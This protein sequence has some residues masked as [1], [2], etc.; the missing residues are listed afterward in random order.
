VKVL[1]CIAW[2]ACFLPASAADWRD[3]LTPPQPGAI[4]ALRPLKAT[5]EFGWSGLT[6]A[7]ANFD[8]AK[9]KGGQM[10]LL[11]KART[12]GAARG[13]WRM[14]TDHVAYCDAVT[15]QPI[16]LEQKEVYK[17][18]S[19]IAKVRFFPDYLERWNESQ[20]PGDTPPKWRK[21]KL[22]AFDLQTALFFIRS[23][24]LETGDVYRIVVYPGKG[25]YLAEVEVIGKEMVKAGG[26]K[27]PAIKCQLRLQGIN[28]ELELEPHAKFKQAFAWLSDDR[29]R[30]L[31][32]A[33]ADVFIGS[34][35]AE[36][37]SIKYTE[38]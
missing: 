24:R 26:K 33:K 16:R 13:L 21:I 1:L 37:T 8:F 9:I 20:P 7:T 36:L 30:L 5:Y 25:A 18:K 31:V 6:A 34:V 14:D 2:L 35:W 10:R 19:E 3:S 12:T 29:D 28:K 11:V 38:R 4:P 32:K 23:Q 17:A 22:G 15:L 27:Y